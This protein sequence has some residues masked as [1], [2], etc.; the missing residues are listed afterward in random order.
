MNVLL[1]DNTL[2]P[3]CWGSAD[4]RRSLAGALDSR[5]GGMT[6]HVR[7]APQEDLPASLDPYDRIILSGSATPA[8]EDAPWIERLLGLVRRALEAGKPLLGVCYGHQILARAVGGPGAVCR[9]AKPEFGWTRIELIESS[10]IFK[11]M[12]REFHSFSSHFDEIQSLPAGMRR[13][14]RSERCG[15]QAC[16][17][18]GRPAFGIQFHP[19]KD[20]EGARRTLAE[21]R[22]K[23]DPKR[24]LNPSRGRDLYDPRVAETLF[25]NFLEL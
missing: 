12:P 9:A 15:I 13:L 1:V 2:D 7:R 8:T 5:S 14:A 11:G 16:A 19:E 17:V 3:D 20:L 24:L 10:P 25:R 4:L 22:R 6:L 18:E 23:G 21:R